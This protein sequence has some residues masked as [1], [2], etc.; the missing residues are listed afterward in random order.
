MMKK[1]EE[2]IAVTDLGSLAS[3]IQQVQQQVHTRFLNDWSLHHQNGKDR[4]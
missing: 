1:N 2:Q 4:D 3:A